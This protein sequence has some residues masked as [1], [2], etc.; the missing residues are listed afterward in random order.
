MYIK[1]ERYLDKICSF[2][3]VDLIIKVLTGVRRCGK[4]ILLGQIEEEFKENGVTD[5][6]IIKVNFENVVFEKKNL[7]KGTHTISV[8]YTGMKNA[9]S[10][11][12]LISID[13]F[14]IMDGDIL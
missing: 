2:Y 3:E 7:K 4:F 8:K 14:D 12:K 6:H 13:A 11:G 5:D 10:N 9:S 1:R